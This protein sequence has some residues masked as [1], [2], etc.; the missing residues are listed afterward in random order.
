MQKRTLGNTGIE[1]TELCFGALPMGPVQKNLPAAQSAEVLAHALRGGIN[2]VDTAQM[3]RTYEPIRIAMQQTGVRPVIASKSAQKTY[4]GMKAAVDEALTALNVDYIDIFHLHAAREG[5]N[6]FQVFEGALECLVEMK[7]Q[8]RIRAVG[9][10]THHV[11]VCSLAAEVES[12]DVVFPI[13]NLAGRG[14]NGGTKE[15]MAA[16]IQKAVAAGKG[17]YLM[18][19]LAGGMLINDYDA[20]LSYARQLSGPASIALGMVST[21]E[22]D[23]NLRYFRGEVDA[24]E[25]K[26]LAGTKKVIVLGFICKKCGKCIETC[27]NAAISFDEKGVACIDDERCL[28]CGYCTPV[29][30]ELAI[31]VI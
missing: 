20:A 21:A 29:C 16:A 22:V 28:A 13:L 30:P 10:S 17:V 25:A 6:A 24:E 11:G 15:Q 12:I 5:E 14:I 2:F 18:K 4:E 27:P 9:I 26:R 31:R 1:V 7:R 8:G 19:V 23:F 3:Y